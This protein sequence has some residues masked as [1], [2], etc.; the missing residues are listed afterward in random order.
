MGVDEF[1]NVDSELRARAIFTYIADNFNYSNCILDPC[2]QFDV[3]DDHPH[4]VRDRATG[5][6]IGMIYYCRKNDCVKYLTPKNPKKFSK[7]SDI[8]LDHYNI[9]YHLPDG[10]IVFWSFNKQRTRE[11]LSNW[12]DIS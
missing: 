8:N 4:V 3:W 9:A 11:R 7:V 10:R 5:R 1:L 2:N 12:K 6:D